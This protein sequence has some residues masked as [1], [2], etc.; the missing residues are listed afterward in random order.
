MGK[1]ILHPPVAPE[2]LSGEFLIRRPGATLADYERLADEDTRLELIDGA[3]IMHSPANIRH[4][5]LFKFLLFLLDGYGTRSG[6][7]Q[8][9]GSRTPLMLDLGLDEARRVEPDI[10]FIRTENLHRLGDTA[11]EGPADLVIEILSPA[12]REY[13]LGEKRGVYADAGVPEYWM[14]DPMDQRFLADRPAGTRVS[15]QK[16][17]RHDSASV[18]GF[19]IDV[20]WLWQTP[21]PDVQACLRQILGV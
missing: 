11:L 15:E 21:T 1:T 8:A 20:G 12:T 5:S 19:W 10:I 17:G 13:D 9:Y 7:G 18:P 6:A 3:L 4:E 16:T 14:I 2:I